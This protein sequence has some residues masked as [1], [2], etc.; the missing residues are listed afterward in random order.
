MSELIILCS[1]LILVILLAVLSPF[2]SGAGG[3]LQDASV[4]DGLDELELRRSALLKRWLRDE[5][6]FN[7]GEITKTE[8][9]QRRSYLTAR[10][11]DISRRLAW[12]KSVSVP[13]EAQR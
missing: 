4:S 2:F 3:L 9:S 7:S 8:W 1:V 12:L 5:A 10:Y 6:A 11:V 13:S